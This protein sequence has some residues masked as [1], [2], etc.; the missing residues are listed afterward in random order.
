MN[1]STCLCPT[2][3]L[4][5]PGDYSSKVVAGFCRVAIL[6]DNMGI[7]WFDGMGIVGGMVIGMVDGVGIDTIRGLG[8]VGGVQIGVVDDLGIEI[9]V[10]VG[11]VGGKG[12]EFVVG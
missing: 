12:F 1:F 10:V 5:T 8:I 3:V 11:I 2:V 4:E 9:V 7:G 6:V